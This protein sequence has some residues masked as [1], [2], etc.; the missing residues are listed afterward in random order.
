VR[1]GFRAQELSDLWPDRHAW[2][3]EEHAAGLF[4]HCLIA[5]RSYATSGET[6]DG[7]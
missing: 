1:A 7:T 6:R 5:M 3:L 4:S 2:I